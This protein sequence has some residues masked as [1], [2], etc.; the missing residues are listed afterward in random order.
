MAS[1]LRKELDSTQQHAS[2]RESQ[3]RQA[4]NLAE[5]R[6]A[7]TVTSLQ[8]EL[9]NAINSKIPSSVIEKCRECPIKDSRITAMQSELSF[10]TSSLDSTRQGLVSSQS[11]AK[12]LHAMVSDLN[13][14][15]LTANGIAEQFRGAAGNAESRLH[16]QEKR[17]KSLTQEIQRL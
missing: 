17:E 6:H 10:L 5:Q 7:D 11:E 14:R 1:T 4:E 2:A 3:I 8:K 15:L 12:E 16:D 9:G 13:A